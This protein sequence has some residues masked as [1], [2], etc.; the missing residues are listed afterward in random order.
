MS[1]RLIQLAWRNLWRN[2]KRTF[3]TMA[4]IAFGYAMLMFVACLMAGLRWQMI[5]NGTSLLLSQIQVHDPGY[6]PNRPIQKTVGGETGTDLTALLSKVTADP[7]VEAVAPRVYGFGMISAADRS[8]GVELLGIDPAKE[9]RVT[10]LQNQMVKGVYLN[11][12][13]PKSIALG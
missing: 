2:Y 13:M 11:E 10:T 7:R 8:Y 12:G 9:A 6:Y 3:I 1:I 4:A 5:E